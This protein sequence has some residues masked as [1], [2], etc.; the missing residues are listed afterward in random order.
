MLIQYAPHGLN[1]TLDLIELGLDLCKGAHDLRMPRGIVRNIAKQPQHHPACAEYR[2]PAADNACDR[3]GC[4]ISETSDDI[5]QLAYLY[6]REYLS[7]GFRGIVPG[8]RQLFIDHITISLYH[9]PL[10]Q[11]NAADVIVS[12]LFL[13]TLRHGDDDLVVALVFLERSHLHAFQVIAER[14]E[15]FIEVFHKLSS[16]R[17]QDDMHLPGILVVE[18]AV[19]VR[20]EDGRHI[21]IPRCGFCEFDT[22]PD[23]DLRSEIF[24]G[25]LHLAKD[26]DAVGLPGHIRRSGQFQSDRRLIIADALDL[27]ILEGA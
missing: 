18:N 5:F 8:H 11:G 22:C 17:H 7:R 12:L 26:R 13:I 20:P 19:K 21:A 1:R 25:K 9:A 14:K 27:H 16:D 10:R 4:R 3:S 15:G 6:R 23:R 2:S 24:P